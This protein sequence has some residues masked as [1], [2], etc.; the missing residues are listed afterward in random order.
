[1]RMTRENSMEIPRLGIGDRVEIGGEKYTIDKMTTAEKLGKLFG[2]D[3]QREVPV[4]WF[5]ESSGKQK[6]A[7][8]PEKDIVLFFA[9]T[10]VETQQHELTHVVEF[11]QEK[12]PR[13]IALYERVKAIITEDSFVDGFTS[14]NFKKNI[15]EFIADGR[16]KTIFI[17]ALKKEGLYDEFLGETEY[18]FVHS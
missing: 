11:H 17:N 15:H 2:I 8:V 5:R 18:L 6:G 3:I 9:N 4:Y 1:M 7:Y 10:D 14:F 16:T 12:N 13:L